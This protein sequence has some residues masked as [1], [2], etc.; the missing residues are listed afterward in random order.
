[1]GDFERAV[2]RFGRLVMA[3][4][5]KMAGFEWMAAELCELMMAAKLCELA[6]ASLAVLGQ[7]AVARHCKLAVVVTLKSDGGA[8]GLLMCKAL[9]WQVCTKNLLVD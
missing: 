7:V 5:L 6:V 1:M 8:Q 4:M 9:G 2:A 3:V